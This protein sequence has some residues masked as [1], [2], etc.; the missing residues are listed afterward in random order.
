MTNYLH[1][2]G[3]VHCGGPACTAVLASRE[4]EL[5]EKIK[6]EEQERKEKELIEKMNEEMLGGSKNINTNNFI[7]KPN[8]SDNPEK[9]LDDSDNETFTAPYASKTFGTVDDPL[10]MNTD[11]NSLPSFKKIGENIAGKG[12]NWAVGTAVCSVAAALSPPPLDVALVPVCALTG[13]VGAGLTLTGE[14]LQK[15]DDKK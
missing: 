6:R 10:F 9:D 7:P 14:K 13:L 1:D 3:D 15:K 12:T 2:G 5:A 11:P 8:N 4:K